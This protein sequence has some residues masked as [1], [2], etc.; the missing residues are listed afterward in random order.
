MTE[1][2]PDWSIPLAERMRPRVL[3]DVVGQSHLLGPNK[4]LSRLLGAE[5]SAGHL[6][7]M[8]FRGPPGTGKTTLSR[9]IADAGEAEFVAISAVTSGIA[10]IR[11][12]IENAKSHRKE[13]E[14]TV[15]FVDE[16]HRFNKSQQDAFLPHIED[17]TIVFIGATTENPSFELNNAL[18]SRA[19]IYALKSLS[20]E[21]IQQVLVRALNDT[22]RGLGQWGLGI[23]E[24]ALMALASAAQGDV[25]RALSLLETAADLAADAGLDKGDT[26]NNDQ[27]HVGQRMIEV[28][29]IQEVVS[30][31]LVRYD[32]KGDFFYDQISALQKAIRGSN[33]DG[34]IYW[35]NRML[36]GGCDPHYLFRRLIR[37]ASEDVGNAD[38]RA[39]PLAISGWDA[40]D[41]LGA[42]E[43]D[44]ALTHVVA[45]LAVAPK[46]NGV[47][48]AHKLASRAVD[49]Y[50]DAEVPIHLRNAPDK[51]ARQMGH[52]RDYRYSHDEPHSYSPGQSYLPPGLAQQTFYQPKDSGLE[53]KI[54]AK[55]AWLQELDEQWSK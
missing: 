39:L 32:K 35:A 7:S 44:L 1:I 38:P 4:P 9:L 8:V 3:R 18:L 42:P 41:R 52:G 11:R 27:G 29:H 34:A 21:H 24:D 13:G 22:K 20:D 54:A 12:A 16:V 23:R 14:S 25:R 46:S 19:R 47:Y 5:S 37:I 6:H 40:Y 48:L 51:L 28:G 30:E 49:D 10:D 55:L 36:K 26:N 15:L 53:K 50:P 33:P 17:G 45:Y 2:G 31:G 43:G